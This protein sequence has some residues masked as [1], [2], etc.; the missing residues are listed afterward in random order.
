MKLIGTARAGAILGVSQGT[1]Q[2]WERRGLLKATFKT[3]NGYRYFDQLEIER[4]ASDIRLDREPG[5]E[6]EE[7]EAMSSP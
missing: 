2:N 7:G 1:V 5:K 4:F 3:E 6:R